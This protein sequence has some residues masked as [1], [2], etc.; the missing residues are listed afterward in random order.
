MVGSNLQLDYLSLYSA[1]VPRR[2]V[3]DRPIER[4][5]SNVVS[6]LKQMP[7]PGPLPGPRV[8]SSTQPNLLNK[9]RN[10][11]GCVVHRA[12][13]VSRSARS[14][15]ASG[16]TFICDALLPPYLDVFPEL[17]Q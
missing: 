11:R 5:P 1:T 15:H 9:G 10:R 13:Y 12:F 16:S 7:Y 3:T 6:L 14:Q 8:A 4:R 2:R 17:F